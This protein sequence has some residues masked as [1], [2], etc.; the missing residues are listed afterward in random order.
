M[1]KMKTAAFLVCF[2]LLFGLATCKNSMSATNFDT[3]SEKNYEETADGYRGALYK[4]EE[5]TA[6]EVKTWLDSCET[7]KKYYAYI[8]SDADSW[9]MFIYY[10]PGETKGYNLKFKIKESTLQVYLTTDTKNSAE[11]LEYALVRVEA[12]RS[13]AWPTDSELYVDN[14]SIEQE[15]TR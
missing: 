12:P 4:K 5:I 9:D 15:I 8:W 1:K 6:L 14:V 10:A 11:R 2:V 7:E 3:E 13:G